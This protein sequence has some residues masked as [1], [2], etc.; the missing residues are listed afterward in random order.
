MGQITRSKWAKLEERT[1]TPGTFEFVASDRGIG[2]L[3]SLWRCQEY[4]GLPDAGKALE[5]ALTDGTSRF[6]PNSRHG[7][8]F[9]PIFIGLVN[10]H[11]ALRFRSGDH[12]LVMD[13]TSPTLSMAQLQQK[14][15]IDGFFASLRCHTSPT[16]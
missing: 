10:L 14:P 16:T 5:A 2:I 11:G 9:R 12:A 4:A 8:G 3:E 6:G 1:H 13:G 7:H 15:F